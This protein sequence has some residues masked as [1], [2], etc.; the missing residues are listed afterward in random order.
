[1]TDKVVRVLRVLEYEY[2]DTTRLDGTTIT[3]AEKMADDL[4][5]W[6]VPAT[7]V[8]VHGATTI[9]SAVFLPQVTESNKDLHEDSYQPDDEDDGYD[10]ERWRSPGSDGIQGGG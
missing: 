2:R 10:S 4:T 9:R 3:A 5:R 8:T 1:M 6:A 7:G